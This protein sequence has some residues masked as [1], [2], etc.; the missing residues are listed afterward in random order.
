MNISTLSADLK[1]KANVGKTFQALLAASVVLNLLQAVGFLSM[2]KTT[3]TVIVPAEIKKPFSVGG[4][5]LAQDYL[6]QMAEFYVSKYA[7]VSPV[8]VDF[9]YSAIVK[10]VD[11][12]VAGPLQ[13]VFKAAADKVKAENVS[14]VFFPSEMRVNLPGNAV[15]F[16]GAMETWVANQKIGAPEIKTF[17]ISFQNRSGNA[18][19]K[20][21][22]E[23]DSQNPFAPV[24]EGKS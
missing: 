15:A 17:L 8:S 13:A 3:R 24:Q 6:E 4:E 1:A 11:P 12:S 19:I 22:R 7:T 14:R 23:A 18:L 20:E 5:Q 21:L 9:Q 10:Q 16:T 2:D